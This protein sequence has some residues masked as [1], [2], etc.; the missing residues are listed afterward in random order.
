MT[1][2][3]SPVLLAF[4]LLTTASSTQAKVW[5][6]VWD[7]PTVGRMT[8]IEG[9]RLPNTKRRV[10]GKYSADKG[11]M[12]GAAKINVFQGIWIENNSNVRCG[13]RRF[14]S[15]HW[16]RFRLEKSGT[17]LMFGS[18]SYCGKAPVTGGRLWNAKR[19][20]PRV[21]VR[22]ES[23]RSFV[24]RWSTA[25]NGMVLERRFPKNGEKLWGS[26]NTDNGRISATQKMGMLRGVWAEDRSNV[27]CRTAKMGSFYWGRIVF[28][29]NK[30][31]KRFIGTW[32]YC[33]GKVDRKWDGNRKK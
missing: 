1:T 32:G 15:H 20:R 11:R 14:G 10:T 25:F 18:W 5:A 23:L 12:F 28:K 8:L 29:L 7:S 33:F 27:R 4:V 13:K 24:G 9:P 3:V 21:V 16:G 17:G 22:R 19:I 31:G 26:Y 6:G 30:S 2:V